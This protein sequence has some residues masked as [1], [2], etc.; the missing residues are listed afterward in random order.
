MIPQNVSSV[1][2]QISHLLTINLEPSLPPTPESDNFANI[3]DGII[4]IKKHLCKYPW[5]HI[6][7][8]DSRAKT[9]NTIAL[10][11][12]HCRFAFKFTRVSSG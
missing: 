3:T 11:Y 8:H 1:S 6:L 9:L 7:E 12:R 5:S 10:I 4:M 2:R